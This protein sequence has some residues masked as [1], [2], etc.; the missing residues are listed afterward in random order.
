[1][2]QELNKSRAAARSAEARAKEASKAKGEYETKLRKL[3]KDSDTMKG[4]CESTNGRSLL[5]Q[6]KNEKLQQELALTQEDLRSSQSGAAATTQQVK[7][8]EQELEAQKAKHQ[9]DSATTSEQLAA[10]DV[11]I[12]GIEQELEAIRTSQTTAMLTQD[13]LLSENDASITD[14]QCRL[15][16]A[17]ADKQIAR[18]FTSL[19]S[20]PSDHWS[21]PDLA[22]ASLPSSN[23]PSTEVSYGGYPSGSQA[24]PGVPTPSWSTQTDLP[25]ACEQDDL[26]ASLVDT[27]KPRVRV[28]T[29]ASLSL[30]TIDVQDDMSM[31]TTSS[32][33]IDLA[34]QDLPASAEPL[35]GQPSDIVSAPKRK[36]THRSQHNNRN[37]NIKRGA[38]R[39]EAAAL[40]LQGD[41]GGKDEEEDEG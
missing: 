1:M 16:R 18:P 2:E 11:Q 5:L 29:I 36:R 40:R 6:E 30:G 20:L 9:N 38:K 39:A 15:E 35:L 33:D 23:C 41:D 14:L 8:L 37:K 34:D 7:C 19:P 22:D 27:G 32:N 26:V 13:A 31:L 25:G 17:E 24:A 21:D 3:Q 10:K 12:N 4:E 28:H